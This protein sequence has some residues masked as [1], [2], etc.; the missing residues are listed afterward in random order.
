MVR[1]TVIS[2]SV[3]SVI[4]EYVSVLRQQNIKFGRVILFGSH[5]KGSASEQSDIDLCVVSEDFGKDYHSDT[6]QLVGATDYIKTAM[7]VVPYNSLDL[8]DKYDPL[9]SEIRKYG[10][11]VS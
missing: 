9:A 7:D 2:S 5:A 11:L 4:H 1:K 6:V 10:L 8:D 3:I